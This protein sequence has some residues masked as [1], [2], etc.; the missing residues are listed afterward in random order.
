VTTPFLYLNMTSYARRDMNVFRIKT[1]V[2]CSDLSDSFEY[3]R[4]LRGKFHK[5][6]VINDLS[7]VFGGLY[8]EMGSTGGWFNRIWRTH[9][10]RPESA[11]QFY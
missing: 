9:V 7:K 10:K 11:F 4:N 2:I 8:V 3:I 1:S 5:T 6:A